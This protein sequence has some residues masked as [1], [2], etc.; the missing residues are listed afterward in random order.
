MPDVSISAPAMTM[1]RSLPPSDD[2]ER[3]FP[4][5][6]TAEED[7]RV[8][9]SI[10]REPPVDVVTNAVVTPDLAEQLVDKARNLADVLDLT[11]TAKAARQ[12][13]FCGKR[14]IYGMFQTR[15]AIS[16]APGSQLR[17]AR[18][19][20]HLSCLGPRYVAARNPLAD[21]GL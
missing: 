4:E 12:L 13:R 1:A 21:F 9:R 15:M 18:Q 3:R 6:V 5:M 7:S 11:L 2:A 16:R 14:L 10:S 19:L 20:A 17:V 8:K